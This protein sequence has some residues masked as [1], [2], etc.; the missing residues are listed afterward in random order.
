MTLTEPTSTQKP[1]RI[2]PHGAGNVSPV[3]CSRAGREGAALEWRGEGRP[4]ECVGVVGWWSIGPETEGRALDRRTRDT[5]H[6][7]P[8]KEGAPQ[9]AMPINY[10]RGKIDSSFWGNLQQG[11]NAQGKEGVSVDILSGCCFEKEGEREK[12]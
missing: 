1:F 2:N 7:L 5:G 12:Y 6:P 10:T 8:Q 9:T 4:T 11:E 3:G